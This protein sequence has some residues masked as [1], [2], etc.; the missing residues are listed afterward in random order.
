M[1]L[2]CI[3]LQTSE[4]SFDPY[5]LN[6]G[7]VSAVAG[8]DFAI[9]ACDTRM[10]GE[11]GYLLESRNHLTNRLWSVHDCPL[12]ENVEESLRSNEA[13]NPSSTITTRP[14]VMIGSSGCSTDCCQLQRNVRADYRAAS[15]FGQI[16]SNSPEAVAEL[17]S[18][19]LYQRRFFPYYSFCVVCGIDDKNGGCGKAY[20]YDAIGSYENVAVAVAGTGRE[21]LQPIL[22]RLF[23][24]VSNNRQV[25]GTADSAIETL[26]KAYR[27][28]SEREI[29]VGDNLVLHI[30]ERKTKNG[31]FS[32]RV[33]VVPLKGH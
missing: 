7:L 10:I 13:V 24:A 19:S 8:K 23:K 2:L 1:W 6:G 17:L 12:M 27:S 28:V 25:E 14:P 15:Y 29:G 21:L 20:L 9:I 31:G 22:D 3:L 16:M 4:A 11:G 5:Q 32:S 18:Q 26:C 30:S 33:V